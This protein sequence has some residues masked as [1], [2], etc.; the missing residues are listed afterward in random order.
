MK[1]IQEDHILFEVYLVQSRCSREGPGPSTRQSAL[2]SL[3]IK[4][5]RLGGFVEGMGAGKGVGNWIGIFLKKNLIKKRKDIHVYRLAGLVLLNWP[6]YQSNLQSQHIPIKIPIWFV[7]EIEKT[8]V[9]FIWKHKQA[10][11]SKTILNNRRI[12]GGTTIPK[13]N[14]TTEL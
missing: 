10:R 3:R 12:I 4:G 2:P 9:N 13:F 8:P 11:I 14:Y 7:S 1:K 5:G 6:S